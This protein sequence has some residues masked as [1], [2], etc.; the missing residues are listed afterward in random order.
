MRRD[1]LTKRELGFE[2]AYWQRA[3][4]ILRPANRDAGK[5]S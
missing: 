2:D 3:A 5:L 1:V 4:G